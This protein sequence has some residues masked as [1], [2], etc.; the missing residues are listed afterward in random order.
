MTGCIPY[1]HDPAQEV[2]VPVE[3]LR[4]F[5]A[6]VLVRKSV[7]QY[8]AQTAAERMIEADLRGLSSHGIRLLPGVV[9]ALDLGDIDPRARVLVENET[10]AV[11]T[12]DGSR[13][14]GQVAA[15]K[16]M[17]LAIQ[18]ARE[19]GTG[20]VTVHHSQHL[21]AASV[22]AALAAQ[23]GL[24]GFCTSTTGGPTVSA[25]GTAGAAVTNSPLAWAIPAGD[26][27]P[28]VVDLATGA[29]S[30]GKLQLLR[31]YGLALPPGVAFEAGGQPA[32]DL[33]AASVLAPGSGGRGFGLSLV[34]MLLS[35]GLAGGKPPHLKTRS[36][37][38]ECSEHLVMAIDVSHFT[39]RGKFLARAAQMRQAI[40]DL[41]AEDPAQPVRVPGDRGWRTAAEYREQGIPLH[42]DDVAR[43]SQ[44]AGK[45]K[46][47]QPWPAAEGT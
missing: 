22:Y 29:A 1:P 43:L 35:G 20:T 27:A 7:F 14:L 11:A 33:D 19:V 39:D 2:R 45:L 6:R 34:A 3:A 42:C 4:D 36:A 16:A 31:Q 23:A 26:E 28:I 24:I 25:P 15:T 41:P 38:S 44:L 12:L 9:E 46:L 32:A 18:K 40:R 13:A 8:D 21:G 30:W 10:A 17:E 37:S 5:V 47:E